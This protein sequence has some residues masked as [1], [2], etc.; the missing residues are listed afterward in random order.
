MTVTKDV[1]RTVCGWC[2][3]GYEQLVQ[4]CVCV[5]SSMNAH[6]SGCSFACRQWGHSSAK[7]QRLAFSS[8]KKKNTCDIWHHF[9]CFTIFGNT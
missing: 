8:F 7:T 5:C 9:R 4:T 6:S 1:C 3:L 2:S